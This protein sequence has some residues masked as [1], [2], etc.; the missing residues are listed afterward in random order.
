[1]RERFEELAPPSRGYTH[2]VMAA[3]ERIKPIPICTYCCKEVRPNELNQE[4]AIGRQ[5]FPKPRPANLKWVVVPSCRRCNER[6]KPDED[7][8]RAL[9]SLSVAGTTPAGESVGET[10]FRAMTSGKDKGLRGAIVRGIKTDVPLHSPSGVY[11]GRVMTQ[12]MEWPRIARVVEKWVRGL[13]LREYGTRLPVDT[14]FQVAQCPD[15]QTPATLGMHLPGKAS[16]PG[17]FECWHR[18]D[19]EADPTKT[20]WLFRVWGGIGFIAVTNQELKI[21]TGDIFL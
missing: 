6:P 20:T 1:M 2:G 18:R 3:D 12:K 5:M 9:L 14:R 19:E 11:V 13:H 10:A 17:I 7:Y 16:W 21:I 8:L 15:A 4:H